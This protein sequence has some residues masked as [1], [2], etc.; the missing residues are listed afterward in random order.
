VTRF[1]TDGWGTDE[2][3]IAPEQHTVG[4]PYLQTLESQPIK[5]RT[6]MK[7]L[8]RRTMCFSK[9]TTMHDRVL[10]LFMNRDEFGVAI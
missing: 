8:V 6:R 10:G 3:R 5:L 2:R 4:K 7:R 1:Y 9:T